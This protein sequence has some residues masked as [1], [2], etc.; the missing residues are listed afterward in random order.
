MPSS[1]ALEEYL[2]K[3][4]DFGYT[5]SVHNQEQRIM[6]IDFSTSISGMNA[7]Q[8]RQD[9]TAHNV[10]NV[11]TDGFSRQNAIQTDATPSGTRIAAITRVPNESARRSNTD[12]AQA[13]GEQIVNHNV[14]GANGKFVRAQDDMTGSL[15]D[16][17]N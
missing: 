2:A 9:V 10:A 1:V 6:A 7:A 13:T 17:F 12:L 8:I 16:I 11:N 5:V 15:L 3:P 14:F 4:P